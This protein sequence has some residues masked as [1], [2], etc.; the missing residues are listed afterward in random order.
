MIQDGCGGDDGGVETLEMTR[1]K[2]AVV[3]RCQ[4]DESSRFADAGG[5]W[6]LDEEV[7]TGG[8]ESFADLE[9]K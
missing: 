8:Q 9:M 4:L 3:P 2:N 5:D 7:N 1:L 6:L